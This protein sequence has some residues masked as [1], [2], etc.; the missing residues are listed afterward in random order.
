MPVIPV[1]QKPSQEDLEFKK[2]WTHKETV[3]NRT[4]ENKKIQVA[5]L[6]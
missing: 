4:K 5:N 3:S 2:F 1:L 6:S